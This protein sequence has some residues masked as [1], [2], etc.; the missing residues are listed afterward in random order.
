MSTFS[1]LTGDTN[2]PQKNLAAT[3]NTFTPLTVT[4]GSTIQTERNAAL[5][6]QQWLRERAT[7]LRHTHSLARSYSC[8]LRR[9]EKVGWAWRKDSTY[10]RTRLC[11]QMTTAYTVHRNSDVSDGVVMRK[12]PILL[13]TAEQQPTDWQPMARH[14]SAGN[15]MDLVC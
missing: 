15:A 3:R 2:S 6:R 8:A 1:F 5:P 7:T 4:R 9:H 13:L 14:R 11:C 12:I 10:S